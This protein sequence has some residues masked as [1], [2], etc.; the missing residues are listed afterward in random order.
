[1]SATSR[2]RMSWAMLVVAVVTWP[3]TALMSL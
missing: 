2:V 1:M 3:V